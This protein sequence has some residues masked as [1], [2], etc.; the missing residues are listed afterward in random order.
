M[1][2]IDRKGLIVSYVEI[3]SS[4]EALRASFDRRYISRQWWPPTRHVYR[5]G[6]AAHHASLYNLEKILLVPLSSLLAP[7]LFPFSTAAASG[8]LA[9]PALSCNNFIYLLNPATYVSRMINGGAKILTPPHS[10]GN[11]PSNEGREPPISRP[12]FH[13]ARTRKSE[14]NGGIFPDCNSPESAGLRI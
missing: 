4:T 1:E 11:I 2:A 10:L 5:T 12:L 3:I 13:R 8:T 6:M 7:S 9:T 14:R